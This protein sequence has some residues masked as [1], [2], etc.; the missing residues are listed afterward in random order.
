MEES[1]P[2]SYKMGKYTHLGNCR[3]CRIT[4][5]SNNHHVSPRRNL[6]EHKHSAANNCVE[7]MRQES[8][9]STKQAAR[10]TLDYRTRSASDLFS[11]DAQESCI[12]SAQESCINCSNCSG[13]F[14]AGEKLRAAGKE[15]GY[16]GKK[17]TKSRS[18]SVVGEKKVGQ[19]CLTRSTSCGNVRNFEY[20]AS[21]T[22]TSSGTDSECSEVFEALS[23]N[24]TC[25]E[26][27]GDVTS[28][29][30]YKGI[31]SMPNLARGVNNNKCN[32]DGTSVVAGGNHLGLEV[33]LSL[34]NGPMQ[35]VIDSKDDKIRSLERT[36]ERL[37]CENKQIKLEQQPGDAT[38]IFTLEKTLESCVRQIEQLEEANRTAQEKVRLLE[39][40]RKNDKECIDILRAQTNDLETKLTKSD[41][42][43]RDVEKDGKN[44]SQ[45]LK[46][47]YEKQIEELR[48][49]LRAKEAKLRDMD[50]VKSRVAKQKQDLENQ[51]I[52]ENELHTKMCEQVMELKRDLQVHQTRLVAIWLWLLQ[53]CTS[54]VIARFMQMSSSNE[55]ATIKSGFIPIKVFVVTFTV[56]ILHV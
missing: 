14:R 11:S 17:G 15:L 27:S 40:L 22:C 48:G 45:W 4:N 10:N 39:D 44:Q 38:K 42:R 32:E 18:R 31:S 29:K 43:V 1:P 13:E 52:S 47:Q 49:A 7:I 21:E 8:A 25:L 55:L 36:I 41:E 54:F 5:M 51:R 24:G 19:R 16:R 35:S 53:F 50:K 33:M 6:R 12:N 23:N 46:Q 37:E 30:T 3:Q 34:I 26:C 56:G 2:Q 28:L 9:P 20:G